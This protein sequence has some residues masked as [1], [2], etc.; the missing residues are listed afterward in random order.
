MT[1]A[2][3][4]ARE[5]AGRACEEGRDRI[6]IAGG[7][8]TISEVANGIL[9]ARAEDERAVTPTLGLLPLGSGGDFGRSLN[10]PRDLD[11]ALSVIAKGATRAVDAGRI[12][13]LQPAS[14]VEANRDSDAP[15]YFVN[16]ASAGLSG[17][18]VRWVGRSAKRMGARL[19]FLAG[20]LAAI[21]THSAARVRVVA[22]GELICDEPISLIVVANGCYFGAGLRVAPNADPADGCF[23]VVVVRGLSA[24]RLLVNLPALLVGRHGGASEGFV[25]AS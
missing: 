20:A 4:D 6:V 13:W 10:L 3:G 1:R 22:D 16:E 25:H 7:D 23:E 19:G 2:A 14:Q 17:A 9:R 15:R 12:D 5:I 21:A 24:S 18:T 8:G 11:G